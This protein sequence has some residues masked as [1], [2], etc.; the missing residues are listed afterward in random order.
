MRA[1]HEHEPSRRT[2]QHE[3][4]RHEHEHEHEHEQSTSTSTSTTMLVDPTT[5]E[6]MGNLYMSIA[7]QMGEVLR[8]TAVSTNIRERLDFSCAVFDAGGG[9]VANAPHI[10]VHLGAMGETIRSLIAEVEVAEG[11]V[12]ASND[13]AA[14]G[15][16][17]PDV[18]VITPVFDR[19][20]LRFFTACRGHHADVGGVTPGSMPA[21]SRTLAEEGCVL[22]HL[23]VVV[24]GRFD[25]AAVR[26]ALARGPHPARRPDD[27]LADLAAQ[28]A[29]N[30][31]GAELM[32]AAIARRGPDVLAYLGH[33]QD[34]AAAL[35]AREI[36]RL[37]DGDHAFGDTLDDGTPIV[38][39]IRVRG[40]R[41]TVDFTGTGGPHPGNLNAP[42]AVTV[43]AVLY[44]LRAMVGAPIPLNAGCL[45]PVD[46][47]VPPG[48]LLD[49]PPG[50]A[51]SGGNVE[52][53]QRIVDVLCGALGLAA[54]SQGT[55]N[56]LTF[57]TP[58]GV[59]PA[60]AYY[61]TI[62]GGAGA[63]SHAA[64]ASA[65][66]T[67]MTNTRITDPEVLEAR[68][69]VRLRRFAVRHGSGGAG[70]H[71][72]GDGVVRELELL[73]PLEISIVSQRRATCPFGLAG[74]GPGAPGKNTL[75]GRDLGGAA[76]AD[77]P[78]GSILRIETPGG[79]GWGEPG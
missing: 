70:R 33:V 55:M 6:V 72:G 28:I 38:V 60:L 59:R 48:S 43:A 9:L 63:T 20:R 45:A 54:A 22:H 49:P 11:A 21:F 23:P 67:H 29:A 40:D 32:R 57:G 65:V 64:G 51:V 2:N 77:A 30:R 7:E 10:P 44:V 25:E 19:G 46:L 47:V 41:M 56:N 34:H 74:G 75:D 62:C 27:N 73:A 15:S 5:R 26:A 8:R 17:L 50:A 3:P 78:T 61:E 18:T 12:Y 58:P 31:A 66:H 42:R 79:G 71:P 69:P 35:V 53:S 37:P 68:F 52:T 14:G 1:E 16:H 36:A 13:P 4:S 39:A 76:R 24:G